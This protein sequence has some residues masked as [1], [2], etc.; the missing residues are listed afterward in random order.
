MIDRIPEVVIPDLS[1]IINHPPGKSSQVA[2]LRFTVRYSVVGGT[3]R[4]L[5]D[6]VCIVEA[7]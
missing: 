6:P 2:M 1:V 7:T 3:S 4:M 5:L